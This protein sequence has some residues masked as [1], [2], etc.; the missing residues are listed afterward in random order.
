MGCV[1]VAADANDVRLT[2]REAT[3]RMIQFAKVFSLYLPGVEM[4]LH[5]TLYGTDT[6]ERQMPLEHLDLLGKDDLLV[7]DRGYPASWLIAA[8]QIRA[9]HFCMRMTASAALP[10]RPLCA[11]AQARRS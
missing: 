8:L 4:M 10:Y 1:W 7:L 6:G 5:A 2:T 3:R 11:A 9:L